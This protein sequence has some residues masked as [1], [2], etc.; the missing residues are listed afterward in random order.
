MLEL[1]KVRTFQVCVERVI[2]LNDYDVWEVLPLCPLLFHSTCRD[3]T[4]KHLCAALLDMDPH[5]LSAQAN[6]IVAPKMTAELLSLSWLLSVETHTC[7]E[8]HS[9]HMPVHIRYN[10]SAT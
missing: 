4:K 7:T 9:A 5:N 3:S 1:V 10:S 2:Q 6:R 8:M